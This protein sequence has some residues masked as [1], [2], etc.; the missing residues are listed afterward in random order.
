MNKDVSLD[1]INHSIQ[2][3]VLN[4]MPG[5]VFIYRADTH[6]ILY[7]NDRFLTMLGYDSLDALTQERGNTFDDIINTADRERVFRDIG[8][9][10]Q[11]SSIGSVDFKVIT[12]NGPPRY[13]EIFC[14]TH[15]LPDFGR[16]TVVFAVDAEAKYLAYSTDRLTELPGQRRFLEYAA[17]WFKLSSMNPASPPIAILYFNLCH[18]KSYNIHFGLD[19]GDALLL[20]MAETLR[21]CFPDDFIA[22]FSDD[23]FVVLTY[24]VDLQ[25]RVIDAH[26]KLLSLYMR[27]PLEV[28]IGIYQVE[29]L[30]ITPSKACDLAKL[31]C[32][33][34]K[35]RLDIFLCE[36]TAKV[37]RA[38]LIRDY[39]ID[40]LDEAFAKG[41]IQVY[42]QPVIRS[43]S[44][45]LCGLEALARWI[46]PVYGFLKPSEFIPALENTRQLYQLDLYILEEVC[47]RI[48]ACL[49]EGVP[50]V[51]ISINLS[52]M[53]FLTCDIFAEVKKRTEK[54][55]IPHHLLCIEITE[56]MFVQNAQEIRII[57]DRFREVGYQVWMD[58]FGS[59][60]SSLNALKDYHFDELKIDMDFL[61]NF[62]QRSKDIIQSTIHMSK[63]IGIRTLAEGVETEEQFRFLRDIGC[64]KIQGYFFGK[65]LPF[66]EM[67]AHITLQHMA[68]ETP[69]LTAYYEKAGDMDFTTDDSLA[70]VETME[71]GKLYFRFASPAYQDV[72]AS[73]GAPTTR[74]SEARLNMPESPIRQ[75]IARLF[76]H[77]YDSDEPYAMTYTIDDQYLWLKVQKIAQLGKRFLMRCKLLNITRN[78]IQIEQMKV[79]GL[80]KDLY[81]L[82]HA[83]I[84]NDLDRGTCQPVVFCRDYH[85]FHPGHTYCYK[86]TMRA[87]GYLS[88]QKEDRPRYEHFMDADTIS[89]RLSAHGGTLSEYFRTLTPNGFVWCQHVFIA[90]PDT[91]CRIFLHTVKTAIPNNLAMENGLVKLY[92]E[93][94]NGWGPGVSDW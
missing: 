9:Q 54:Y 44:K 61:S 41:Y 5:G 18:F 84:I 51:P 90:I 78:A 52:R 36:Y 22:R 74:D 65:P 64:E 31:A 92:N 69:E 83:I 4:A 93:I 26:K 77:V 85:K 53:D 38:V 13:L 76:S 24:D 27:S 55:Q 2:N 42:Y 37:Q 16:V 46:D 3:G 7:A 48:R 63:K 15:T 8:H 47:K 1:V 59:G 45:T 39:V 79:N 68:I 6:D 33:S 89:D 35:D 32:D 80:E 72:L 50:V 87:F 21:K 23:H 91:H 34:I 75:K 19:A 56:S 70:I 62:T 81:H 67:K 60:Y 28:K 86:K 10:L 40:H 14:R 11:Q 43:I 58:D 82:Y 71:D 30:S 17:K 20:H 12:K 25:N 49:D 29:D 94:K 57:L 66:D 73:V 88:I